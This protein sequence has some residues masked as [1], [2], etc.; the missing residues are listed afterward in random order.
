MAFVIVGIGIILFGAYKAF[1]SRRVLVDPAYRSWAAW[2]GAL[3]VLAIPYE[4]NLVGQEL[5]LD[6]GG[7]LSK[8]YVVAVAIGG[9]LVGFALLD[10]T[11]RVS[12]SLDYFHRDILLWQQIGRLAAWAIAITG[13]LSY[14]ILSFF[15]GIIIAIVALLYHLA[16]LL[17]SLRRAHESAILD[18]I[19]WWGVTLAG[20]VIAASF[21]IFTGYNFLQVF[22]AYSFYRTAGSLSGGTFHFD[23][24]RTID[25]PM[26]FVFS[27]YTNPEMLTRITKS[28]RSVSLQGKDADGRDVVRAESQILGRTFYFTVIRKYLPPNAM[29]EEAIS[30]VGIGGTR[31]TF[32]DENGGTRLNCSLDF[33]PKG[34]LSKLVRGLSTRQIRRQFDQDFETGKKYCE[35]NRPA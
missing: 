18:Y 10:R 28:Y 29:E 23:F 12:L 7:P 14:W 1:A 30:D 22:V 31:F 24:S 34:A 9:A 6:L 20:A 19:R 27:V 3:L 35:T 21:A 13:L 17:V 26:D 33:E 8:A 32:K 16:V 2:T 25:A 4:A 11:I 15:Y 5:G